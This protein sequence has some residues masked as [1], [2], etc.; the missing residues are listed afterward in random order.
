M[1]HSG[2]LVHKAFHR[3]VVRA[4]NGHRQLNHDGRHSSDGS[5]GTKLRQYNEEKHRKEISSLL[6]KW[7][8]TIA[9]VSVIYLQAPGR[10]RQWFFFDSGPLQKVSYTLL[11]HSPQLAG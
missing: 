2:P 9:T 6:L 8:D 1:M 7:H 4:K 5:H 10:N 3:Y 11:C